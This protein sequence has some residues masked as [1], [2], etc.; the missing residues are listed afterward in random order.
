MARPLNERIA[1]IEQRE[2]KLKQEKK[3]LLAEQSKQNRNARTKRLIEVGAVVEKALGRSLDTP[4]MRNALLTVLTNH[5]IRFNDGSEMT[6]A[7]LIN[8][9]TQ[10]ISKR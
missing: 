9:L 10:E 4:E 6:Y 1:E 7:E 8:D 2:N 5:S 3:K